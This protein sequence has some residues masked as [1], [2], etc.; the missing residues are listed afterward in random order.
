MQRLLTAQRE[1]SDN[2][3]HELRTP[4]VHL[5]TRLLH[6]IDHNRDAGVADD[7]DGARGDIRSIVSLF[8]ALLDLTLAEAGSD[9]A[10]RGTVDV[11]ELAAGLADL[12]AASAGEAGLDFSTRIAPDVT[13]RGEAIALTR[14]IANLLDNAIKHV[15][16]GTRVR[17]IVGAGPIIAVEDNGTGVAPHDREPIFRRFH[18]ASGERNGHGLGLAL[19]RVIAA[20]HGLTARVEDARPGARFIV[21]PMPIRGAA[22]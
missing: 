20:Q 22:R 4:L 17:R 2:I 12:Y 19:V 9:S 18:R 3:E 1:I 8:D 14:L 21:E 15:P 11:S 5:D 6:A 13:M 7:L 10:S 16:A